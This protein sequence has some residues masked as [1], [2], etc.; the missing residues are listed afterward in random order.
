MRLAGIDPNHVTFVTLLSGCADFPSEGKLF[1]SSI[2]GYVR[3]LGLDVENVSVGTVLVAMYA[4]CGLVEL[5]RN[6]FD[7]MP[8][9]NSMSWNTMIDGYMRNGRVVEAV[10]L[11]DEMP[12]K[13]AIS[14]TALI[15][16]FVKMGH[17]ED[18]LGLFREMQMSG[19]VPDYVTIIAVLAACANLGTLALGLW[20]HRF[21]TKHNLMDNVKVSNSLIDMYSRCGCIEFAQCVFD[22]MAKRTVVSWNSIIVGFAINGYPEEALRYFNLMQKEGFEPNGVTFTGALTACS[23]AG[24]VDDGLRYFDMMKRVHKIEPRIEHYG[25]IV[26]LYSRAGRLENA[27]GVIENMPMKANEVVFGSLL[28]ACSSHGNVELAERLIEYLVELDPN[29]DSNYVLLS[30]TYAAL[31]RWDVAS[32]ARKRMKALGI[33]KKPGLSSIEVGCSL[34]EFAAGDKSHVETEN[35]YAVL[36]LLLLELK[37]SGYVPNTITDE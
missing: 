33:Q 30:N 26:D 15:N 16:G 28:A 20:T 19:V 1:G 13:D 9:K 4:K 35:I 31:G 7:E 37:H 25:C 6:M 23:H 36:E 11:F 3:K 21:I 34:H 29:A 10:T 24:L 22:R 8:V 32:K 12:K 2:H 17:F 27:M 5:A 18:A 14:W